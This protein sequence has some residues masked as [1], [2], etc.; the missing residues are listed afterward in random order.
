MSISCVS[1]RYCDGRREHEPPRGSREREIVPYPKK[2]AAR[3][4]C[5]RHLHTRTK[6]SIKHVCPR[7]SHLGDRYQT[8]LRYAASDK[9]LQTGIATINPITSPVELTFQRISDDVTDGSILAEWTS[10][11]GGGDGVILGLPIRVTGD[12]RQMKKV[13]LDEVCVE[14]GIDGVATFAVCANEW[15]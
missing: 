9:E 5:S 6:A 13:G 1:L 10:R 15:D 8:V 3:A 14:S 7:C 12:V 2:S 11:Q 4:R